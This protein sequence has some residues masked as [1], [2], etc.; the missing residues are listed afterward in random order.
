MASGLPVLGVRKINVIVTVVKEADGLQSEAIAVVPVDAR[1]I[2][3]RH[4]FDPGLALE[5]AERKFVRHPG[6]YGF[7]HGENRGFKPELD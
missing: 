2:L 6:A 7:G 1:R 5:T 4:N 3:R